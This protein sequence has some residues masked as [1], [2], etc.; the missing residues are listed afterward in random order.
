MKIV[1]EKKDCQKETSYPYIGISKT[2]GCIVLFYSDGEGT[3]LNA[4]HTSNELAHYSRAWLESCFDRLEG[5]I[6]LSND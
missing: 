4:G 1:I 2:N 6:T 5:S 3:C